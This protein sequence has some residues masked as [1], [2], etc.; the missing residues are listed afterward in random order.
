MTRRPRGQ[1]CECVGCGR[2]F[3][4]TTAFDAHLRNAPHWDCVDPSTL[5]WGPDSARAGESK[6]VLVERASGPT[7]SWAD[8]RPAFYERPSSSPQKGST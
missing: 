2:F 5:T 4:S 3:S 8:E 7:W 1:E 6:L